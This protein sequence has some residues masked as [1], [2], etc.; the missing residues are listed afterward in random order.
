MRPQSAFNLSIAPS[1]GTTRSGPGGRGELLEIAQT[2]VVPSTRGKKTGDR[3]APVASGHSRNSASEGIAAPVSK[4]RLCPFSPNTV[5]R[6]SHCAASTDQGPI[7]ITTASPSSASPSRSTPTTSLPR[8]NSPVTLPSR[9]FAPRAFAARIIPAVKAAGCT[10]AVVPIDPSWPWIETFGE[11]HPALLHVRQMWM[12]DQE[13]RHRW[14]SDGIPNRRHAFRKFGVQR[15]AAAS[16]M[17][18]RRSVAPVHRQEPARL[19]RGGA[20][21]RATLDD[22]DPGAFTAR[23]WAIEA[24][25]TP[26][27]TIKA[28]MP[29][30]VSIFPD[31][32]LLAD[33]LDRYTLAYDNRVF[34]PFGGNVGRG[35]SLRP[36]SLHAAQVRGQFAR[37]T[38]RYEPVA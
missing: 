25:M 2:Y 10:C 13:R 17:H 15:E 22:N 8:R 31:S 37:T 36:R 32:S 1:S 18:Q 27:P 28:R 33:S 38:M 29:C 9:N 14:S 30:S 23:W 21:N 35:I 26:P 7:A 11:S 3:I 5:G 34:Q 24:P 19:A 20:G 16:E 6:G 4:T 12:N